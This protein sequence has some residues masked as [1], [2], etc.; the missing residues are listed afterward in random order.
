M[1]WVP[2]GHELHTIRRA[3]AWTRTLSSKC[4]TK[5]RR[6][7]KIPAG[8]VESEKKKNEKSEKR[9]SKRRKEKKDFRKILKGK[10]K[11]RKGIMRW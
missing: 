11:T 10:S 1:L 9:F 2:A 7:L 8:K 5:R 3:H 6:K 4:R